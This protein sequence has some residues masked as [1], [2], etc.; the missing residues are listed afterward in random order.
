[1]RSICICIALGLLA[2]L[3]HAGPSHPREAPPPPKEPHPSK[4]D[5]RYI[6]Q[7]VK[8]GDLCPKVGAMPLVVSG[9]TFSYPWRLQASTLVKVGTIDGVIARSGKVSTTVKLDHPYPEA[10]A[11]LSPLELDRVKTV[12]IAFSGTKHHTAKLTLDLG[13]KL[14][15]AVVWATPGSDPSDERTAAAPPPPPKQAKPSTPAPSAP[16][17][18]RSRPSRAEPSPPAPP[19]PPPPP[20]N[21]HRHSDCV[22]KCWGTEDTCKY[23]CEQDESTCKSRCDNGDGWSACLSKCGED[24]RTCG[25]RCSADGQSCVFGCPSD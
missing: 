25:D 12:P 16:A 4:W 22:G 2:G 8:G 6:V 20:R 23:R 15:C 18:E 24:G 14:Q 10:V 17:P 1:M 19:P 13:A 11:S 21:E 3:A 5:G 9:G 7:S